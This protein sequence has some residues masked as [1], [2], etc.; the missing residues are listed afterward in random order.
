[1]KI[2]AKLLSDRCVRTG[3]IRASYAY[4]FEPYKSDEAAEAKY[5]L[6]VIIPKDDKETLAV[7]E[8]AIEAAKKAGIEKFGKAWASRCRMP[9]HDGDTDKEEDT[10]YADSFFINSNNRRKPKVYDEEGKPTDDSTVVYSGCYGSA[11]IEFYPYQKKTNQ[12]ISASLIGFMKTEDGEP[13]GGGD[14]DVAAGFGIEESDDDFL[15]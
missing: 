8:Q 4:V 6:S 9:L 14:V 11:M 3:K 5:S 1:M 15:S 7:I 10:A 12:G 2:T 13:L